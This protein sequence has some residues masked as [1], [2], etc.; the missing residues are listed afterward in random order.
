MEL[1]IAIIN[2]TSVVKDDDVAKATPDLQTQVTEHFAPLWGIGASVEFFPKRRAPTDYMRLVL[3]DT[4]DDADFLGY[5]DLTP[6]GRAQSKV[7]CKGMGK[8]WTMT[9]SHEILEMLADRYVNKIAS[10]ELED[11]GMRLYSIEVCDPV[12]EQTYR[13]GPT[14]VSNFVTEAWFY[15]AQRKWSMYDYLK[16]LKTPFTLARGGYI[17]VYTFGDGKGW[18]DLTHNQEN[19]TKRARVGSRRERRRVPQHLLRKSTK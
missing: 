12:Q 8:K 2:E 15:P 3:L 4:A 18:H 16:K 6:S 14:E 17:T 7:F 11:G 5:H 1:R 9:A 19:L 10:L 13:I